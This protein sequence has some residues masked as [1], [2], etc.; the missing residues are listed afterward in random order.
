[1]REVSD[2][3]REMRNAFASRAG[4][5]PGDTC[6]AAVR[7]Y[8]L[9]AQVQALEM[10]AEWVL[11]QAFPQTAEGKHLDAHAEMRA[12]SRRAG[13]AATGSIIFSAREAAAEDRTI[14]RG[15]VCMTADGLRFATTE[16]AILPAGETETEAPAQA[17]TVGEAGN[18]AAGAIVKLAQMP[19]GVDACE[20]VMPFSGG[21][22][23]ES[24]ESL[25]ARILESYARLPNGANAA[26]YEQEA[27]KDPDVV[28]AKAVSRAHGIGTVD[29][30]VATHAGVPE[31]AVLDRIA[32]DLQEKREIAV[33]VQ[34]LAPQTESVNVSA[35][36]AVRDGY[37]F[38]AVKTAV[39]AAVRAFFGGALLEKGVPAAQLGALIFGV[40]GVA[41]CHLLSPTT[42]LA[43]EE[44]QLPVLGTLTVTQI[45]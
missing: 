28:A 19:A 34:V 31:Q 24:D 13:T 30:I 14:P 3:Y 7:L 36:I 2:I 18:V 10:Q 40:E 6:D 37:D 5:V 39:E 29:V 35:K 8:A 38:A 42:D 4:F 23:E 11:D 25:R 12:L 16:G 32:A 21:A 27:L 45:E 20:N 15:T 1:M 33:D 17:L 44:K 41:N 26:F 9:A 43:A 22:E